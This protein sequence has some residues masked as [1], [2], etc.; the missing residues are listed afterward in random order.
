[1]E[2]L[3]KKWCSRR[4]WPFPAW[5]H[6]LVVICLIKISLFRP[7]RTR[8]ESSLTVLMETC[9]FWHSLRSEMI[10]VSECGRNKFI[11]IHFHHEIKSTKAQN[12]I[13]LISQPFWWAQLG[14]FYEQNMKNGKTSLYKDDLGRLEAWSDSSA[15]LFCVCLMKDKNFPLLIRQ[16]WLWRDVFTS[17]SQPFWRVQ[18]WAYDHHLHNRPP[19]TKNNWAFSIL[20]SQR[21]CE[22]Y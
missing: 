3:N 18:C 7:L 16:Y 1:M 13:E 22:M 9:L 12:I 19:N 11:Q 4:R 20:S 21:C 8:E 15:V 5:T 17:I 6:N 10:S 14:N 2:N